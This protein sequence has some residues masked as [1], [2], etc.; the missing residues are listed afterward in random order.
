[1]SQIAMAAFNVLTSDGYQNFWHNI[2]EKK[3][4]GAKILCSHTVPLDIF[5]HRSDRTYNIFKSV[6]AFEEVCNS[7]LITNIF[8]CVQIL[9]C[10]FFD[11][12]YK[13]NFINTVYLFSIVRRRSYDSFKSNVDILKW[14]V[15]DMWINLT[16]RMMC[17][18]INQSLEWLGTWICSSKSKSC[19]PLHYGLCFFSDFHCLIR[20]TWCNSFLCTYN[21]CIFFFLIS[22]L[23][24]PWCLLLQDF[25]L[26][27]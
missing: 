12:L 13:H 17:N 18:T 20:R 24:R 5:L 19:W 26:W 15:N 23:K 22:N 9:I 4:L 6:S 8:C 1:M 11:L 3:S 10:L 27:K 2:L 16:M 25:L 21:G 14:Y 7:S